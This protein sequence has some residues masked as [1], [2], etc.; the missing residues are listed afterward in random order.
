MPEQRSEVCPACRFPDGQHQ[1]G[2]P[3]MPPLQTTEHIYS[4]MLT[5]AAHRTAA[6]LDVLLHAERQRSRT[7]Q[8]MPEGTKRCR[9]EVIVVATGEYEAIVHVGHDGKLTLETCS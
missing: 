1:E 3:A 9:Y 4:T 5:P 7:V 8:W 2:C 6:A